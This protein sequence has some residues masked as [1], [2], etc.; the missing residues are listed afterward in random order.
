MNNSS[1][2]AQKLALLMQ[3]V[4]RALIGVSVVKMVPCMVKV[5]TLDSPTFLEF[6]QGPV[7]FGKIS[8]EPS[9]FGNSM[10][11]KRTG[12]PF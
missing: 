9:E 12:L 10:Q 4:G 2:M 11:S 5:C 7:E 6:R 8:F 1:T 3:Y